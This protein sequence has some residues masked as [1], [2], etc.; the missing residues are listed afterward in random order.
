MKAKISPSGTP[1]SER[2]R[3]ARSKVAAGA[4]TCRARTP[5]QLAGES[6]KIRAGREGTSEHSTIQHRAQE[7]DQHRERKRSKKGYDGQRSNDEHPVAARVGGDPAG[8]LFQQ[9]QVPGTRPPEY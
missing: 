9:R 4:S 1:D 5:P 2:N 6:R 3:T 8:V 7:P